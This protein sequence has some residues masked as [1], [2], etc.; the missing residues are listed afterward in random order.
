MG[1]KKLVIFVMFIYVKLLKFAMFIYAGTTGLSDFLA[2]KLS[3]ESIIGL[4]LFSLLGV[5]A[6]KKT[7]F[8]AASFPMVSVFS[9]NG[10][11]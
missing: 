7:N 6:L 3:Q 2:L 1:D 5:D 9:Q 4:L 11:V 10:K 8:M